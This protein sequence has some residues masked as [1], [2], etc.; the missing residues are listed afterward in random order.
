MVD[1]SWFSVIGRQILWG[2]AISLLSWGTSFAQEVS[3]PLETGV[4]ECQVLES[5][6]LEAELIVVGRVVA[7]HPIKS[8]KLPTSKRD[9]PGE[10]IVVLEL[11]VAERV[12]APREL[13]QI[14]VVEPSTEAGVQPSRVGQVMLAFM[15]RV[16]R[17]D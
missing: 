17:I 3:V 14:F 6:V 7:V 10:P 8:P 5:M 16:F 2:A 11:E 15:K 13:T 4:S 12:M 1:L 9:G